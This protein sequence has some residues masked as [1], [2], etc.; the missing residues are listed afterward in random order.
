MAHLNAVQLQL[1]NIIYNQHSH[2]NMVPPAVDINMLHVITATVKIDRCEVLY[3]K[4]FA[5]ISGD[6]WE[7]I[8]LVEQT[9]HDVLVVL[10]QVPTVTQAGME[11]SPLLLMRQPQQRSH[12]VERDVH[13]VLVQ[14]IPFD[15]IFVLGF[16]RIVFLVVMAV[17]PE[18]FL[19]VLVGHR[20]LKTTSI[21]YSTGNGFLYWTYNYGER[22]LQFL[23]LETIWM[24]NFEPWLGTAKVPEKIAVAKFG[25]Y[26]TRAAHI[27]VTFALEKIK[28]I[29]QTESISCST[30]NE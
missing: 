24:M 25:A 30:V 3:R 22:L 6:V 26:M 11:H 27:V 7:Q 28:I 23:R 9:H 5:A 1:G 8:L 15:D 13:V 16:R 2:L 12:L 18:E 17:H 29:E 21:Y 14:N 10:N 19:I 4:H 20:L